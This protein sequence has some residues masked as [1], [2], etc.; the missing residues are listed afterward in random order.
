MFKDTSVD[1]SDDDD[2]SLEQDY[3][4]ADEQWHGVGQKLKS[5]KENLLKASKLM[6]D[7]FETDSALVVKN[8]QPILISQKPFH[9]IQS[10]LNLV[11]PLILLNNTNN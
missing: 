4:S 3:W 1:E 9:L 2:S 5:L 7:Y 10:S 6:E 11:K 8:L